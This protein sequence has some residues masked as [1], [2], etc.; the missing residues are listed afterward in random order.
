MKKYFVILF[1]FFLVCPLSALSLPSYM[2]IYNKDKFAKAAQKNKCSVC[3]PNP[4][5]GGGLNNFGKAFKEGG[6]KITSDLRN[7]FP[8][9]FDLAAA[10]KPQIKRAKPNKLIAGAVVTLALKGKNF[11]SDS[12]LLI[13]GLSA[14]DVEGAEVSFVSATQ[15]TLTITFSE[16]GV[17]TLQIQDALGQTSNVFKIKVK[18]PKA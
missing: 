17:H 10:T 14:S 6:F 7:Q 18:P 5:G 9:L 11:S 12:T 1:L 13:D 3:H 8:E 15:I 2:E 16:A 4:S